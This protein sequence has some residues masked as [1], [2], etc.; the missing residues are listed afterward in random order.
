MRPT[1]RL[2]IQ[3]Q[4]NQGTTEV[5]P[6]QKGVIQGCILCPGLLNLHSE[7]II[8]TERVVEMDAGIGK[9]T[10]RINTTTHAGDTTVLDESNDDISELI[11]W[12]RSNSEKVSLSLNHQKT[13]VMRTVDKVNI[14]LDC[15]NS[16]RVTNYNLLIVLIT[17]DSYT[18]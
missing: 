10:W 12:D 18:N 13:T 2:R 17:N 11:K 15:E 1:Y 4:V 9:L 6:I 8:R 3:V 7:Y 14:C 5:F 16:S